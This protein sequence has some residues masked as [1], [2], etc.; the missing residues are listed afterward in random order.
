MSISKQTY[1]INKR[2]LKKYQIMKIGKLKYI[3]HGISK[4]RFF[5]V[6]K[7]NDTKFKQFEI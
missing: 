2:V 7:H 4:K 6:D 1:G 3:P 5:K